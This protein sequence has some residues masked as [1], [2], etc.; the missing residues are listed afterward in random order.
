MIEIVRART[1]KMTASTRTPDG[2]PTRCPV[3][4]TDVVI[5]PSDDLSDAPCP[6]CG[7]LIWPIRVEAQA[8]CFDA[9]ELSMDQR[10]WLIETIERWDSLDSL[11]QAE[12]I[13][14]VESRLS[15]NVPDAEA[16]RWRDAGDFLRWLAHQTRDGGTG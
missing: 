10:S 12:A 3:C 5:S 7:V 8:V 13:V 14:E 16:A 2:Y 11:S 1:A 6:A 15:I 4:R 9:D